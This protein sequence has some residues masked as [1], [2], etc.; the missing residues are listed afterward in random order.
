MKSL[1]SED[2]HRNLPCP[3]TKTSD[4]YQEKHAEGASSAPGGPVKR[5][6][7]E[8]SLGTRM[9][10]T[11]ELRQPPCQGAFEKK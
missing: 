4:K 3:H 11:Q 2:A 9:R 1:T 6:F 7:I 10:T 5:R 8:L